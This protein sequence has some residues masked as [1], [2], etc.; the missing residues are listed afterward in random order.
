M[1]LREKTLTAAACA[2]AV[3]CASGGAALASPAQPD[4]DTGHYYYECVPTN[5]TSYWLQPGEKTTNCKGSYLHQYINGQLVQNIHLTPDG[6]VATE[7]Q[8]DPSVECVI[9]ITTTAYG[10]LT[11]N[12]TVA[13]VMASLGGAATL[14]T[15]VSA[16]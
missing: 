14:S 6:E 16:G 4:E 1:R 13:W 11:A 10:I 15:C 2:I 3:A 12:G 5:G 9:G 7:Y 8:F